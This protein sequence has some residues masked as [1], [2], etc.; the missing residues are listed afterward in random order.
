MSYCCWLHEML[1]IRIVTAL[2][3]SL[4]LLELQAKISTE[5]FGGAES[6]FWSIGYSLALSAQRT[7]VMAIERS[8]RQPLP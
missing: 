4:E 3:K 6:S 8:V 1:Q 5:V 7:R 2:V